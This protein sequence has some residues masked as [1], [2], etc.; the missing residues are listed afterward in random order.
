[1]T[2]AAIVANL[3]GDARPKTTILGP[4]S[5]SPEL[6][7]LSFTYQ[8]R[9]WGQRPC[10]GDGPSCN[11]ET[12]GRSVVRKWSVG[13]YIGLTNCKYHLTY[14]SGRYY[15]SYIRNMS[16]CTYVHMC[17]HMYTCPYMY[18]CVHIYMCI[19]D[20]NIG[21][22]LGPYSTVHL[23][24]GLMWSRPSGAC[25]LRVPGCT[26]GLSFGAPFPGLVLRNVI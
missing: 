9:C 1:M 23:D 16:K 11:S 21:N 24:A 10:E 6:R 4:S 3:T 7:A 2:L 19:W 18:I 12:H 14:I 17:T 5:Q 20:H 22:D 13:Q 25:N 8:K 26:L 15:Y